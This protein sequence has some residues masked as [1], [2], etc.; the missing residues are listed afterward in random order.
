MQPRPS[1]KDRIEATKEAH[2][3]WARE[4]INKAIERLKLAGKKLLESPFY[5]SATVVET[6]REV[7]ETGRAIKEGV[8]AK[9][10]K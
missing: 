10:K 5:A 1:F 9:K 8:H 7:G 3:V 4:Q 6:G 2:K